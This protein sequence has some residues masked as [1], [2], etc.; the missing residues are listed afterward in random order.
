MVSGRQG[1]SKVTASLPVAVACGFMASICW[2][3]FELQT[4]GMED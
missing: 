2:V 4:L 1:S 3:L